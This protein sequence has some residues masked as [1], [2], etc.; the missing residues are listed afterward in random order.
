M[1]KWIKVKPATSTTTQVISAAT[2]VSVI[3]NGS[4]VTF[5]TDNGGKYDWLSDNT[6]VSWQNLINGLELNDAI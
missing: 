5:V 1:V 2:V 6:G 3:Q 4:K